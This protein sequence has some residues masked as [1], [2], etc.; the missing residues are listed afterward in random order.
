MLRKIPYG[1][2]AFGFLLLPAFAVK[3]APMEHRFTWAFVV[4]GIFLLF[5]I[6][7]LVDPRGLGAKPGRPYTQRYRRIWGLTLG[8][9]FTIAELLAVAFTY[10]RPDDGALGEVAEAAVVI[11]SAVFPAIEKYA[12]FVEPPLP[13]E[14][15]LRAQ[16]I[17][18]VFFLASVCGLIA[19]LVYFSQMPFDERM[20]A[21]KNS[22][23]PK[24]EFVVV[25]CCAAALCAMAIVFF[26]W[27]DYS[28][29]PARTRRRF[30]GCLMKPHC[31][32]RNSD[33]IVLLSASFKAMV[34]FGFSVGALIMVCA[35]IPKSE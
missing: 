4:C 27:T 32:A 21:Q 26:G 28:P 14:L 29:D 18:A 12:I 31:F 8:G 25:L 24:S 6:A 19:S 7:M 15:L 3:A 17:T 33:I 16:S 9:T 30:M 35:R 13:P 20:E 5:V 34:L 10:A 22:R 23:Q 1:W 2:I 11:G